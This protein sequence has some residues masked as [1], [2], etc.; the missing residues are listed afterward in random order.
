[1]AL[2]VGAHINSCDDQLLAQIMAS[3]T[4][5]S[6]Q[7][8]SVMEAMVQDDAFTADLLALYKDHM[9]KLALCFATHLKRTLSE[10]D[11]KE[12]SQLLRALSDWYNQ[13]V[14]I[15][16]NEQ[17]MSTSAMQESLML[18][19]MQLLQLMQHP[20]SAAL[21]ARMMNVY[22]QAQEEPEIFA[23]FGTNCALLFGECLQRIDVELQQ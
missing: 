2:I 1:M 19:Q 11:Q 23:S 9:N 22:A 6:V 16:M 8:V 17:K 10:A 20:L 15:A 18:H 21:L 4:P 13:Y 12:L 5:E 3:I 7:T 14:T